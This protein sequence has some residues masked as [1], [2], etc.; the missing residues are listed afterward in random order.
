MITFGAHPALNQGNRFPLVKLPGNYA[1]ASLQLIGFENPKSEGKI[2]RELL[3]RLSRNI[4][5]LR[6]SPKN[7]PKVPEHKL[8]KLLQAL[9]D[10]Q[11]LFIAAKTA[12]EDVYWG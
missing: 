9:D 7:K 5:L 11:I 10:L 1:A 8:E 6:N 12:G 3:P 4:I 2:H